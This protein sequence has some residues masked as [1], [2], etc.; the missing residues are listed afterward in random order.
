MPMDC[1]FCKMI[2]R[3]I[4][5]EIVYENDDAIA[6]LDIHP[7]TLGHTM[8]IPKIH[9]ET[10][11]DLPDEKINGV[12]KAVKKMTGIINKTL[13]PDGFTLGINHGSVSGQT[14]KH[15]HIHIMPRWENDKG[16]SVHSV[17]DNSPTES[18]KEIADRIRTMNS[19]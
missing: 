15:L 16:G 8:V 14:V 19:E 7:R 3:E 10:I 11:L 2:N 9:V 18:I 17:V 4:P 6:I 5:A 1:V 12:F 13:S